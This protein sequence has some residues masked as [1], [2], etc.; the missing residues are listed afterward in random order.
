[1]DQ[2]DLEKMDE[3]AA[4]RCCLDFNNIIGNN[5]TEKV[6]T[7]AVVLTRMQY[8]SARSSGIMPNILI[9]SP[10]V[11][12][13]LQVTGNLVEAEGNGILN[14][15]KLTYVGTAFSKWEVFV[16]PTTFQ[17]HR[18]LMTNLGQA[19]GVFLSDKP[20]HYVRLS[21]MNFIMSNSFGYYNMP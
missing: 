7:L 12:A 17:E 18:I 6:Q 14:A 2:I 20:E 3:L 16:D 9:V 4:D 21:L 19:S 15:T 1:M 8:I 5:L 13:I 11:M 10:L